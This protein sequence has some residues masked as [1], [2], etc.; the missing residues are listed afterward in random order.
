M[1]IVV[2]AKEVLDPDAVNNYILAGN[3]KIGADG[4]TPEVAAIPRLINGFDEQAMEAALK[5]RD[6]GVECKIT[7]VSIGTDQIP[8]TGTEFR[9]LRAL[10]MRSS[11]VIRRDVLLAT[12][13]VHAQH[14]SS[15]SLDGHISRLRTKLGRY[16][17]WIRTFKGVGYRFVPT[18]LP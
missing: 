9:I 17:S 15:R 11:A 7:A 13:R 6:S 4:K 5:I 16:G 3:L 2:C 10:L 18:V 12:V 8:L 14:I 1:R